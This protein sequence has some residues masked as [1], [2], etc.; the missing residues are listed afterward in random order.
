MNDGLERLAAVP[1]HDWVDKDV[2]LRITAEAARHHGVFTREFA[3]EAGASTSLISRRAKSGAWFH[4]LPSV[5]VVSGS[6]ATWQRA[7]TVAVFGSGR[8][9]VASHATA[10]HL[11]D[12]VKRPRVIEVTTSNDWRPPRDH[13]IHRSTDLIGDD[14]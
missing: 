3:L 9:A 10:A 11:W 12:L 1:Y 13:V 2:S 7:V 6:P 4:P 8:G 14:I 5:Y